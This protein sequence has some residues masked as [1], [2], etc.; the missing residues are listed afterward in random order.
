MF[1][2]IQNYKIYIL[3]YIYKLLA[4]MI[5]TEPNDSDKKWTCYITAIIVIIV[6]ILFLFI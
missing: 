5:S 1:L 2:L 4:R 3:Y 6:I